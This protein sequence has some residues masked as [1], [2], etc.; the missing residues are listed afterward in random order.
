MNIYE[1]KVHDSFELENNNDQ[2][3]ELLT[4]ITRVPGGWIYN[5]THTLYS[6]SSSVFV[7]LSYEGAHRPLPKPMPIEVDE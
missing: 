4:F 5:Q 6:G 3:S 2:E 7:P 1:M